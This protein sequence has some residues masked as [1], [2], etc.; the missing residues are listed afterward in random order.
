MKRILKY[1]RR[2]KHKTQPEQEFTFCNYSKTIRLMPQ[3]YMVASTDHGYY[4]TDTDAA[5]SDE[6]SVKIFILLR[7][8]DVKFERNLDNVLASL[9]LLLKH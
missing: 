3:N 1:F 9:N 8:H 6:L 2:N 5:I 7:H 4:I